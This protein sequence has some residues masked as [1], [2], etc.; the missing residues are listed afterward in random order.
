MN[1]YEKRWEKIQ[2]DLKKENADAFVSMQEGNN[3]YLCCAHIPS[4]PLVTHVIIP[5][6]GEPV[7]IASS[8][9]QFRATDE[10][11]IKNLKIRRTHI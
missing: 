3:R 8:L 9:E 1:T 5:K 7:A 11:A 10:C 4:F 2:G 6:K